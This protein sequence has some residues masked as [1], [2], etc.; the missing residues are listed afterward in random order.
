[1][2]LWEEMFL[3]YEIIGMPF[4]YQLVLLLNIILASFY[5]CY[6]SNRLDTIIFSGH[7]KVEN[8]SFCHV[9][10]FY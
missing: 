2:I 7:S 5:M 6:F 3:S 8:F 4:A 1:M 10:H 9:F